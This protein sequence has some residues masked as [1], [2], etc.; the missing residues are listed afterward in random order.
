MKYQFDNPPTREAMILE[1]GAD[2]ERL[3]RAEESIKACAMHADDFEEGK[4][5]YTGGEVARILMDCGLVE[6][7]ALLCT[8]MGRMRGE[9]VIYRPR[10]GEVVGGLLRV[11]AEFD[12][13]GRLETING[14]VDTGD[15][16]ILQEILCQA[17]RPAG[18][19]ER[20]LTEIEN[21]E[22]WRSVLKYGTIPDAVTVIRYP[23]SVTQ[24]YRKF[25][26]E[27]W[28][29]PDVPTIERLVCSL[30][31]DCYELIETNAYTGFDRFEIRF[32]EYLEIQT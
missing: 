10:R 20:C 24:A 19:R 8:R 16:F 6:A 28:C 21:Y 31:R 29:D 13:S 23:L 27:R 32:P 26:V 14:T 12:S 22:H 7:F 9:I 2:P 5:H 30:D 11:Y 1:F 17:P 4:E 15:P 18:W 25:I 3:T